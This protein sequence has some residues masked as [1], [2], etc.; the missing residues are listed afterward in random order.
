MTAST[1]QAGA[2]EDLTT[3]LDF[4]HEANSEAKT[5]NDVRTIVVNL[6]AGFSANST[7]VPTCTPNQLLAVGAN[8][9]RTTQCP[10]ASQI[11]QISFAV[12]SPTH[13]GTP[14]VRVTVPLYNMEVTSFGVAA[15][16]GFKSAVLTQMLV[17]SVRPGDSGLT[18]TTPNIAKAEPREISVTVWGLPAG[19][20]HDTQRGEVCES[21][22][23]ERGEEACFNPLAEANSGRPPEANVPVKPFLSNPTSCGSFTATMEA[24]SWEQ[25]ATVLQ[26]GAEAGP[27]GEC[28]RVPFEPSIE[29]QP[30]TRSAE[31][32]TGLAVSL[33]VPQAWSNPYSVA[34]ANLKDTTVAL[35]EGMTVNPS[36]GSG[37][38]A[39]SPAQYEA[40]TAESLPGEGCPPESKIGSIEI[41]TPVLAEKIGGAVY[42]ATPYD[43]RAEFA[44]PGHPDGSLLALYVVAKVPDRGI[45]IKVA[46]RV[47]L[48][49]V[50]GQ[51]VTTFENTPQ[52][53]FSKF[54]L[55]FRPG[56]TAPLVSPSTCGSYAANGALTPWSAPS[57]PRL[58]SSPPF[59]IS[60]GVHEGPCPSGGVPSFKPQVISGTQNNASGSYS[61][62]YLRIVREDGEQELTKFTTVLPPGL[63]GNLT[64][65]PFCPDAGIEAA[66]GVT[67][68]EEE[69]HPSCPVASEI[70]HT[71]VE[72]GVGSV[73]AQTPG[74]I[75]LAGPYNGAP[76][77]IVSITS[78]K[79]GP[80][81]LGTVV[82]R[83]A[84]DINPI[85]AQVEVSGAQSDP[86]PHII[87]GIVVHVRDIRVYMDRPD[88][89]LN[90]TNC[91]PLAIT[92]AI[93]GSGANPANPADQ[94]A[95][96]VSTPFE[97]ADCSSLGFKPVFKV[98]TSSKTS[99]ADGASLSVKLTVPGAPGTQAN[100]KSVKVDLPK[101]LPSRLTTLQKAC[102]A[103]VFETNPS[104]CPANS[105]VGVAKAITPILPVPL[106]GPAY[107]VSYGDLKFP[108]LIVVLQGY[109]F[110]I[111]LHGE[112]FISKK[113]ITSSTFR[114]VPDQPV[115][116]FEL[117][118]P[119]GRY[120]ALANN[121]NLC[122][123]KGGLKM[124]T[125]LIAQNGATIHESTT[126]SV[127]GCPK[128]NARKTKQNAKRRNAHGK[129]R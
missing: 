125:A 45:V 97:T 31:S 127:G 17:V 40:E 51:L 109:G 47:Q 43:N 93:T 29:V 119:R 123:V 80:F 110:T 103:R 61:P 7:A 14:P 79:V 37:L 54:T 104:A 83:F 71:I 113:G 122:T 5:F 60:Q 73:L 63:T 108:E 8:S 56:A 72:A 88:F 35:P 86:I 95:V 24:N 90:P 91:S 106:E 65:I 98:A 57:D 32:P 62:F 64:G 85:T 9:V 92:D 94:D 121:G 38:G 2:H 15:E 102:V 126:I 87:K 129:K 120:S 76:L 12:G 21:L 55:K 78:A 20:E 111:D 128:H 48:N 75:Y 41:E 53:P 36:A 117:T 33:L 49:P 105:R 68:A 107:F 70:G 42:V 89:T 115:T 58:V 99:R 59:E 44:E 82:I 11:G 28:E 22:R 114:T 74:K 39:C 66:R 13:A 6:P 18:V 84:L 112:T 19:H 96:D 27:I 1:V 26:A 46:G 101:Q 116:S 67:G 50:T 10:V 30:S 124:P 77:S 34:T 100:I 118:L 25:P 16:L 69:E 3:S 52:Q 23:S 81:D 4:A